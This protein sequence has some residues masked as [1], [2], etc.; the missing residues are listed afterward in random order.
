MQK[1]TLFCVHNYNYIIKTSPPRK[2][3]GDT[4]VL[5]RCEESFS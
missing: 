1:K 5:R 4:F 2:K 3:R